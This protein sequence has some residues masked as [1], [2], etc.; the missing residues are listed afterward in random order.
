M[1]RLRWTGLAVALL[2]CA[3]GASQWWT[4]PAA[5]VPPMASS[6]ARHQ[7]LTLK[8]QP[9]FNG[10]P[11]QLNDVRYRTAAG[12]LI[13]FTRL[14]FLVTQVVLVR[15]DGGT[16]PV[17]GV[18]GFFDIGAG[19]TTLR[20]PDV[21]PGVYQRIRFNVG[22]EP[23]RNHADPSVFA[24]RHALNPLVNGLHWGWS[25]GYVFLALE[26]RYELSGQQPGRLGGFV[27]HV[28]NDDNLMAVDASLDIAVQPAVGEPAVVLELDLATLFNQALKT[29]LSVALGSDRTHSSPDDVSARAL[30]RAVPLAFRGRQLQA[31]A[32][33]P[34]DAALAP[35]GRARLAHLT[36]AKLDVPPGFPQPDL[37]ADNPLTEEGIRLGRRLFFE[38]ALSINH[39]QSCASCHA[40]QSAFSDKGR[41]LSRGA[42][43]ALGTRNAMPLFNLAW[44][45]SFAWDG[46]RTRLR[47]QALAPISDHREMALP[48]DQL[49][50]RL[51][52]QRGYRQQFEAVFGEPRIT[53]AQV[54]LALEQFMLSLVSVDARFDQALRR[55][56]TL[57]EQEKDGLRLFLSEHDPARGVRGADCFHC[58]GGPLFTNGRFHNNGLDQQFKDRGRALVTDRAADE[59]LFKTPSLRNVALT[60]P[61]MHDGRFKTLEQVVEH[62]SSGTLPSPTLDPNIAKHP[63]Q[64]GVDLTPAEKAALVAFLK[65]LTDERF[66]RAAAGV[67]GP[68]ATRPR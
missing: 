27:F 3:W 32:V 51:E 35:S 59:G 57:S 62:Y 20:L 29:P 48:A 22:V 66:V 61:Y 64:A 13:G 1:P 49:V 5:V 68:Q 2:A 55:E 42:T 6:E 43:R 34:P 26:G 53:T 25:G 30:A 10:E 31:Q 19:L 33:L 41:A 46:R 11:V 52:H 36:A 15:A 28:A 54:G 67:D 4:A 8:F 12:D 50:Q 16:V 9:L 24:A 39:T 14:A 44:S 65:T 56:T 47:D 40:P 63:N 7:A 23:A 38:P 18:D 21:P 60:A 58:H 17:P 45:A 37:P